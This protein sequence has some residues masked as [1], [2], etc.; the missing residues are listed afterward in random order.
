MELVLVLL[1]VLV[2]LVLALLVRESVLRPLDHIHRSLRSL[3]CT[4]DSSHLPSTL[5]LHQ[6]FAAAMLVPPVCHQLAQSALFV[7]IAVEEWFYRLRR[8]ETG[9]L[10]DVE[11]ACLQDMVARA[12]RRRS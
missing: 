12:L 3:P 11:M 8:Q 1:L 10:F 5:N 2:G 9:W 4:H 6:T 7:F